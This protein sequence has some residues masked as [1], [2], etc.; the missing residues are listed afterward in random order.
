MDKLENLR[1]YMR[2]LRLY[3]NGICKKLDNDLQ[4]QVNIVIFKDDINQIKYS[5]LPEYHEMN[6]DLTLTKE[7][8]MDGYLETEDLNQFITSIYS[9]YDERNHHYS[10]YSKLVKYEELIVCVR[11]VFNNKAIRKNIILK[12]LKFESFV[13]ASLQ[14]VI[15]EININLE[16]L[17]EER[18]F[19]ELDYKQ[20]LIKAAKKVINILWEKPLFDN[21]FYKIN[22][23]SSLY[24]ESTENTGKILI[25]KKEHIKNHHPNLKKIL[26]LDKKVPFK[27]ERLVRKLLEI[28]DSNVALLSDSE[29]I[30][31]IGK[32]IEPFQ[33]S[34]EEIFVIN[35][36]G[37]YSWEFLYNNKKIMKVNYD[38]VF[39]P[40]QKVTYTTFKKRILEIYRDA[41]DNKIYKLYQIMLRALE[42]EHGTMLVISKNARSESKR[43]ESQ[44]FMV[45]PQVIDPSIVKEITSI[46]GAV[47]VDLE[48]VCHGIGVILDGMATKNGDTSRGARYNSAIRYVETIKNEKDYSDCLAIVISEDGYVDLVSKYTIGRFNR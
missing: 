12:K 14:Q 45:K 33:E 26:V 32:I 23:I 6:K 21:L 25:T 15:E 13:D 31:G 47:L 5:L 46:D 16:L 10:L 30:Y 20:T 28:C 39:L 35:F 42:Q 27:N 4:P 41:P 1:R 34:L 43:L 44:C 18:N 48:C 37:I 36:L 8:S 11:L 40:Q 22:K 7:M 29:F 24:Y 38:N 17:I 19:I 2:F 9:D 3:L